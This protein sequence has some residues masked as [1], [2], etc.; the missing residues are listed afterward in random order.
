MY[1]GRIVE[2]GPAQAIF[3]GSQHPYTRALILARP[4][5][6]SE[7]PPHLMLRGEIASATAPPPGCAF[8]P[9]CWLR[10]QLGNPD[11]CETKLP[12]LPTSEGR[13]VAA[14]HFADHTTE[15]FEREVRT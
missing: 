6:D 3:E 2:Q 9:R 13:H 1:L 15:G 14:C 7:G 10:E 8:H 5:V 12:L 4:D 11:A